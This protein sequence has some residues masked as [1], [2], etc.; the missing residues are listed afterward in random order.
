[1]ATLILGTVGSAVAGPIGGVAGSVV[2]GLIDQWL[3]GSL[4]PPIKGPRLNEI[5]LPSFDEG[6]PAP[7][8]Q[9]PTSRVACQVIW[10]GSSE[11]FNKVEERK[12]T[13]GGGKGG[14]KPKTT[15]YDYFV[16]LAIA[17]SRQALSTDPCRKL[18]AN[19]Q[20]IFDADKV[21][22]ASSSNVKVIKNTISKTFNSVCVSK[23][24][25]EQ[26]I[27]E[28]QSSSTF[29]KD[30][31]FDAGPN[32]VVVT[33]F[34]N[35]A[36]NGTF[37]VLKVETVS[38]KSRMTVSKCLHR[39]ISGGTR[40]SPT[41]T[42]SSSCTPGVNENAGAS[43]SF[44]QTMDKWDK[45]LIEDVVQYNG[46]PS[47]TADPTITA[48]MG[49]G[50]VPA[51][52][53]TSY[54]VLK[55]LKVTNWGGSI[56]AFEA[57][58]RE[59]STRTVGDALVAVITRNGALTSDDVDVTGVSG[60]LQLLGLVMMGPKDPKSM[61]QM[62]M[63]V[64]D[65]EVQERAVVEGGVFKNRLTFFSKA[66][67][68][69]RAVADADRGAHAPDA[70]DARDII[71]VEQTDPDLL[72]GAII[73]Q[74]VDPN[75]DYQPGSR[76]YRRANAHTETQSQISLPMTLTASNVLALAKKLMWQF[77]TNGRLK[78]NVTL[79]PTYIDLAEADRIT[80]SDVDGLAL[81]ARV[82]KV[83]RGANGLL[84]VEA[85]QEVE[86]VYSEPSTGE[87]PPG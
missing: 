51:Y 83:D 46:S 64:Y 65:L 44:T 61:V 80:V 19:G 45:G 2:G 77:Q 23:P 74:F 86:T 3:F 1:M 25:Q 79:P 84:G 31:K 81:R 18:W 15:Q 82:S 10:M 30:A 5:R 9:G 63:N 50:N 68:D 43:A 70:E 57:L 72:P 59:N 58:V 34:A 75:E 20:L 60:S 73:V 28:H 53:S 16:S 12:S 47:Q 36:N 7:W 55:N 13:S 27:Y 41:C 29:F 17:F 49:S 21:A 14:G 4:Q 48:I 24:D 38:S 42:D 85:L 37:T 6:A 11:G 62:L 35:G 67:A 54:I 71:G 39:W 78:V 87:D 66:S 26:I 40:F 69:L 22:S 32:P 33:G 76:T 56:P 52:R 8:V